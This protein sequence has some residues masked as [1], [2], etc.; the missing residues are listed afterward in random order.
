MC[1]LIVPFSTLRQNGDN[2]AFLFYY[3]QGIL[4]GLSHRQS[5]ICHGLH[6]NHRALRTD[7]VKHTQ[8]GIE[9]TTCDS[10]NKLHSYV[11]ITQ[12]EYNIYPEIL[13]LE[14]WKF[15]K[16]MKWEE[17]DIDINKENITYESKHNSEI[18]KIPFTTRRTMGSALD[19]Y[20][21]AVEWKRIC[22]DDTVV[23]I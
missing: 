4:Y 22:L 8:A 21:Q 20:F 6:D 19:L 17:Q 18:Q 5:S 9:F 23:Y 15:D 12:S 7:L 16:F 10:C 13:C 3:Q 14:D 2:F 11:H 1:S